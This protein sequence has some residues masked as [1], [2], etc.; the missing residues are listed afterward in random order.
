M[1][2]ISFLYGIYKYKNFKEKEYKLKKKTIEQWG[3][4]SS[5]RNMK[6]KWIKRT[7]IFPWIFYTIQKVYLIK[8]KNIFKLYT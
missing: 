5:F 2:N 7:K 6:K 1:N 8:I 4:C 3:A